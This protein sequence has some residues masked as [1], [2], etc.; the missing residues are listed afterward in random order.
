MFRSSKTIGPASW[1]AGG[2]IASINNPFIAFALNAGVIDVDYLLEI[3]DST[4]SLTGLIPFPTQP[5]SFTVSGDYF[6][7]PIFT[8][9]PK[10]VSREVSRLRKGTAQIFGF[11]RLYTHLGIDANGN[12]V[13]TKGENHLRNFEDFVKKY[14]KN[15]E[16]KGDTYLVLRA[17]KENVHAKV[18]IQNFMWTRSAQTS[19][20]TY[21]WNMTLKIYDSV[22]A[23]EN[24]FA[25]DILNNFENIVVDRINA[26]SGILDTASGAISGT[27]G[28]ATGTVASI[29]KAAEGAIDS[30]QTLL[31]S[32][33]VV[34]DGIRRIANSFTSFWKSALSL[35]LNAWPSR[36]HMNIFQRP[37]ADEV[38]STE[39]QTINEAGVAGEGADPNLEVTS[40]ALAVQDIMYHLFVLEGYLGRAS[41]RT[42]QQSE[43]KGFLGSETGYDRLAQLLASTES[44]PVRRLKNGQSQIE[45]TLKSGES[46]LNI[47]HSFLGDSE[48]WQELAEINDYKDAH[49]KRNGDR[50]NTGDRIYIPLDVPVTPQIDSIS[51]QSIKD[52]IGTDLA[53]VDG[54]LVLDHDLQLVSGDDNVIQFVSTRIKTLAGEITTSPQFGGH[55]LVGSRMSIQTSLLYSALIREELLK[56]VRIVDVSDISFISESDF[57]DVQFAVQPLGA[58]SI[59]FRAPLDAGL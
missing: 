26:V 49:T 46:L 15:L 7:N 2:A 23:G 34:R 12:L 13:N 17:L 18:G 38:A 20:F 58:E 6:E 1:G 19:R 57:V 37:H 4:G 9:D 25:F 14:M 50:A 5:F 3:H 56:D 8:L 35:N 42:L 24:P 55:S 59:T 22:D 21:E 41:R 40:A 39:N 44:V 36:S 27:I 54:D 43:L 53:L 31:D 30:T 28:Q 29:L 33:N 11:S 45:Y 16:E 10:H 52:A 51:N 32:P 47:A 48:R